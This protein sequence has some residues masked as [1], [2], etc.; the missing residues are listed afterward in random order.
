M[1]LWRNLGNSSSVRACLYVC[2]RVQHACM[3]CVCVHVCSVHM[4]GVCMYVC[5]YVCVYILCICVVCVLQAYSLYC[6]VHI[7]YVSMGYTDACM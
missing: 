1:T 2:V 7:L 6:D 5:V 4:C 3:C